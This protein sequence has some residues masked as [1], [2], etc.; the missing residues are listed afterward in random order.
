MSIDQPRPES[1][2]AVST[3]SALALLEQR[4]GLTRGGTSVLG[5]A[6]ALVVTGRLLP[7]RG[8]ALV[9]YGLVVMLVLSWVLGRRNLS[10]EATRSELPRRVPARRTI[11]AELTVTSTRRQSA[12]VI[13][14]K[15]DQQLGDSMRLGV[16]VLI[17][18]VEV[19]HSYAFTPQVR[20]VFDV[21]PMLVEFSDPFGLTRR[22]QTIAE[23]ETV[24]VHPVVEPVM[25]RIISREWEDPPIRP[26]VS[27]PWP[28]GFEFYGM[29]D[30][31]HG[32]DP[33]RIVWR[34][35]AQYGKYMVREAE[36]GITDRVNLY[37]DSDVE[38]HSPG[39][40]S[41]T[42][43]VAV[44]VAASLG[45]R[46]LKDGFSVSLDTNVQRH[47]K[48]FRGIG[49]RI[50]LLDLLAQVNPERTSL[51]LLLERMFVDPQRNA[52]NVVITPRISQSAASRMRLLLERGTSLVVVLVL[53]D[54]TEPMTVHR[55]GGLRCNVIEVTPGIPLGSVFAAV[56]K[57]KVR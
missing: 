50:P 14:E 21:G 27:R 13:E 33:R 47:A 26:P 35:L 23:P 46:H 11:E 7:N 12:V 49:K 24:I 9:G 43:E 25:D 48:N 53:S 57:S 40:P 37:L 4:V 1:G 39:R 18:G 22:R 29:R 17:P 56:G 42:F 2:S 34:A 15:L 20:G 31:V 10:I 36:Q 55:A 54:E 30:Y 3:M 44:S 41:P 16:P 45:V 52:H 28:T 51:D 6:A 8:L 38:S 5:L 32:D 19:R